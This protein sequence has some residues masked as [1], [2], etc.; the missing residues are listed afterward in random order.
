MFD[1]NTIPIEELEKDLQDSR[2]DIS[3]CAVALAHGIETYSGGSVVSRLNANKRFV[4]IITTELNR[5]AK[6]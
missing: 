2:N 3:V 1:I 5:R 4:E 6:L